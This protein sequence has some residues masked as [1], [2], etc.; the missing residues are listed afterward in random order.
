MTKLK[1]I[2]KGDS[3]IWV[4]YFILTILSVIAVYSSVGYTAASQDESPFGYILMHIIFIV[5]AYV[6]III[7]SV[8]DYKKIYPYLRLIYPII[9]LLLIFTL[10][11]GRGGRWISISGLT[12]QP[13]EIAKVFIIAFMARTLVSMQQVIKEKST[14]Y[15]L[16]AFIIPIFLPI[17]ISNYSTASLILVVCY[18]MMLY[19]GVRKKYWFI[20]LATGFAVVFIFLYICYKHP[21]I[22]PQ[23]EYTRFYTWGNRIDSWLNPSYSEL[24]Q[25]NISR[26]AISRGGLFGSGSGNTIHA[27]LITQAENDFIFSFIIEEYGS[28]GGLALFFLYNIFFFRCIRIVISC[29]DLFGKLLVAGYGS[30]IYIQALLHMS[31]TV[32]LIP[33]T[34]Q[35]LPFISKG[36]S[37][38]IV[39]SVGI[40]II[41]SVAYNTRLEKNKKNQEQQI[42]THHESNH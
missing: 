13:S 9:I 39:M 8:F 37:A 32:G 27:R 21:E 29:N 14:F 22:L 12:L 38:Y 11:I 40:G 36:G 23:N 15:K 5:I 18:I 31:V 34:G 33:V 25:E 1:N 28:L 42:S 4:I 2:F 16:L 19:G 6:V 17:F 35:T 30:L 10:A 3:G 20:G 7:C 41:Q 24:T 26:M